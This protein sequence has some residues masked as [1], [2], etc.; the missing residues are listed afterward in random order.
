[1][2]GYFISLIKYK[3]TTTTT[4]TTKEQQTNPKQNKKNKNKTKS[5]TK[6]KTKQTKTK[7]KQF[8]TKT[9]RIDTLLAMF[10]LFD[11]LQLLRMLKLWISEIVSFWNNA[12]YTLKNC[13]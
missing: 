9:Y 7:T 8:S 1:M 4:T 12:I 3:T 6:S 10:F 5:K 2:Y 11:A 13:V